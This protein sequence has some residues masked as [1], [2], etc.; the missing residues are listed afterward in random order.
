MNIFIFVSET[1]V[2]GDRWNQRHFVRKMDE[3]DKIRRV[4]RKICKISFHY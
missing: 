4:E 2:T 1:T 3:K